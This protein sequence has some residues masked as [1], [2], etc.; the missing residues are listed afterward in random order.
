MVISMKMRWVLL[1]VL[2]MVLSS[3]TNLVK[4]EYENPYAEQK[5]E[6][7]KL[8]AYLSKP[9]G[10]GPFPAVVLL[11]GY[12]GVSP[13]SRMWAER[14]NDW[15]YATLTVD[16]YGPRWLVNG[17]SGEVSKEERACDAYA[18]KSYL[19]DSPFIDPNRMALMGFANGGESAMCAINKKCL[20]DPPES[21]FAA[22]IAFYPECTG[23]LTSNAS[24]LLVLIGEKDDWAS[25][26]ACR[27]LEAEPKGAYEADFAFYADAYHG[28]DVRGCNKIYMG[29]RVK[30]DKPAADDAEIRIKAFL[31]KYL[32]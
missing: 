27:R 17:S 7:L 8:K 21:P 10:D 29:H 2:F 5:G 1:G 12:S 9:E 25:A 6:T 32:R 16:S 24:P 22:A 28:F 4:F 13:R 14:L 20:P 30:Y 31:W 11:H 19:S 3:C 15:G 23:N 26:E 18:A